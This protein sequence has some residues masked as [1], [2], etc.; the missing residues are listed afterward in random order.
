MYVRIARFEGGDMEE[1]EAEGALLRDGIAALKR[2]ESSAEMPSRL[3]EVAD[4]VEILV[5]QH[6]GSVALCVYCDS[7]DK[8]HEADSILSGM[9]PTNKGFGERVSADI[10]E[11]TLDEPMGVR[12]AASTGAA[13][14]TAATASWAGRSGFAAPPPH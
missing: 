4:R 5:D 13:R 10:Y 3:A 2:G 1:I 6:R 7:A 11:V 14:E 8:A 12:G 9:S